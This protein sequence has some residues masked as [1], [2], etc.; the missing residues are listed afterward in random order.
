MISRSSS[1][2]S[3]RLILASSSPRRLALLK[4]VCLVP[5]L[6]IPADIDETPQRSEQPQKLAQRL[7]IEKARAVNEL[8]PEDIV[9]AADTVVGCGRRILA[10]VR[11]KNEARQH[12]EL[13]SGRRHRVFSGVCVQDSHGKVKS[14]LVTTIV[15]FKRL[16]REDID[17]YVASEEWIGKAGA[18]AIQGR[19]ASHVRRINGSYT[20]VVG[21]PLFETCALLRD[22]GISID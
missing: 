8:Y 18:Y 5:D 14:R 16:S 11:D 9:L 15:T 1:S 10:Q 2:Q 3:P 20:N 19:A 13:L 4:Q 6:T 21:L 7:A 22:A 17:S 12:L